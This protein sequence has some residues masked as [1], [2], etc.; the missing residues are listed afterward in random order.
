[1]CTLII[2]LA[3]IVAWVLWEW[4][5]AKYPMVPGALFKGQ[6]IVALA[7]FVAFA[8]GLNFYSVLNLFPITFTNVYEP[9]PVK[10]GLRSMA[11]TISI[12]IGAV[13][14]NSALSKF[15]GHTREILFFAVVLMT[16]FAGALAVM[17]PENEKTVIGLGSIAS[18]GIGGVLVPAATLAMIVCPDALITTAAALSLSIRTIGGSIGY[19]IY[20]NIFTTKLE[21]NLPAYVAEYAVKAGLPATSVQSFVDLYLTEPE[22][23]VTTNIQGVTEAVIAGAAK[24]SQWAYSQSLKYVWVS[25]Y[26]FIPTFD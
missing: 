20:Y 15:P 22:K 8:A 3:L 1:M 11:P 18:F 16:T 14:F 17:T 25:Y 10:I 6:R 2:G 24:G 7:Y 9:D 26:K 4:K 5:V 23:L 21:K 13:V 12:A 19:A